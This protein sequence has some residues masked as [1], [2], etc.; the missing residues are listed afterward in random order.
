MLGTSSVRELAARLGLHRSG[1]QWRGK[2]PGCG[3][4]DTF[5]LTER[6]GRVLG[7][8]ASC[9]DQ[10]FVAHLLRGEDYAGAPPTHAAEQ[11]R[12]REWKR[13]RALEL[14]RGSRPAS[15]TPA[16]VYLKTRG[17]DGLPASRALRFCSDCPHPAGRR[18]PAL[19][20][21]VTDADDW[22][23][24]IHRTFLRPDGTAKA[25]VEP[26]RATLG[27][28]WG[29]TVRLDPL[30]PEIVVGEGIESSAS[31][32]RLLGAPAWAAISA[33][34]LARGVRLPSEV[35]KVWIAVDNDPP[36]RK[37]AYHAWMRWSAEGRE[38]R[39]ATP[40]GEGLDFN[41]ILMAAPKVA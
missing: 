28:F 32:G 38:V 37:A 16:N 40:D 18:L 30:A 25:N 2:C 19:I 31:A 22:P 29:G 20:A 3:Y 21:L 7:W 1:R 9:R 27:A 23:L 39:T 11:I 8:C 24:G 33:G 6:Q 36:G 4:P 17:L 26:Q 41:D 10:S 12:L 5:M 35:R 15:S 34:N 13:E 14:W